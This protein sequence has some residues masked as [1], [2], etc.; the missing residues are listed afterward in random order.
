MLFICYSRCSTCK[1][2]QK[3]LDD[4]HIDYDYRDIKENNPSYEELETWYRNSNLEIKKF[5]NTSGQLYKS[6]NLKEVIPNN[7]LEDNLKLLASDGMLVKRPLLIDGDKVIVG[8]K[9][10]EYKE[11]LN[12]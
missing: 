12:L 4:N 1:K 9:E 6:M 8:F 5:F 2:A 11:Y 10:A 3:F 7:S